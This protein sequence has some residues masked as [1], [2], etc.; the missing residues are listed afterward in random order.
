MRSASQSVQ[1]SR[2][3]RAGTVTGLFLLLY[4]VF[5][6]GIEFV[7]IPDDGLYLAWG[8]LTRGQ[9][10][11]MPMIVA[12]IV[13]LALAYRRPQFEAMRAT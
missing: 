7:R 4:G 8:W 11:S 2:Q 9:L 3:P 10:Y 13:L 12:G 1:R 6:V 5:R